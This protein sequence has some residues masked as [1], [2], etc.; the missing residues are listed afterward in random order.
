MVHIYFLWY[1]TLSAHMHLNVHL[2]ITIRCLLAGF[3]FTCLFIL[4]QCNV[5]ALS[6]TN[7]NGGKLLRL[8]H[9]MGADYVHFR[10]QYLVLIYLRSGNYLK[11]V[12]QRATQAD[13]YIGLTHLI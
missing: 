8:G 1:Y 11:Y 5:I 9:S 13:S 4:I 2:N 3:K 12:S 6:N 10:C 7:G